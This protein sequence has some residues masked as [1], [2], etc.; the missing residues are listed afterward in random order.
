MRA[1]SSSTLRIRSSWAAAAFTSGTFS[2]ASP[3][4]SA[5]AGPEGMSFVMRS[6]SRTGGD[7]AAARRV[8]QVVHKK[9]IPGV[10]GALDDVQLVGETPLRRRGEW[11]AVAFRR[12]GARQVH[13]Q[14]VIARELRRSRVLRQ[15]VALL[16]IELAPVG[17]ALRL[18]DRVGALRE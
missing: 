1:P 7:A 3:S 9:E 13:E 18:R 15:E 14:V 6:T 16:E 10:P 2:A 17:D 11:G 5:Y 12:A 8:E 4:V